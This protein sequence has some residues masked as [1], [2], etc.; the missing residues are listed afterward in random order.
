MQ[1]V[2]HVR[3]HVLTIPLA[4]LAYHPSPTH[5]A[6]G[7]P[8]QRRPV[9][10]LDIAEAL[11][12]RVARWGWWCI[13]RQAQALRGE[14]RMLCT[15]RLLRPPGAGR[16]RGSSARVWLID[17]TMTPHTTRSLFNACTYY[18][19]G[20]GHG[21]RLNVLPGMATQKSTKTAWDEEKQ[22]EVTPADR[23]MLREDIKVRLAGRQAGR[24]CPRDAFCTIGFTSTH[25]RA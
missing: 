23:F 20:P 9:S 21:R 17:G 10:T 25:A 4:P 16:P 13:G 12:R 22:Y 8:P 15:K 1:G 6:L 5:S 14:A 19:R 11:A 3:I 24:A 2:L 18:T 7:R